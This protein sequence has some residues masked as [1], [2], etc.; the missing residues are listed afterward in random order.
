MVVF[1]EMLGSVNHETLQILFI[2]AY[3]EEVFLNFEFNFIKIGR[4]YHI[5]P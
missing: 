1:I 3:L 2:Y 4:L 5:A